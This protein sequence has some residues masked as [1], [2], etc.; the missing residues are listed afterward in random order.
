MSYS[1]LS[2]ASESLFSRKSWAL[3]FFARK[4][5]EGGKCNFEII[6]KTDIYIFFYQYIWTFFS[7]MF[8]FTFCTFTFWLI[9]YVIDTFVE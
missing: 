4:I 2:R 5:E 3:N 1:I 6:C 8:A 7:R 9:T